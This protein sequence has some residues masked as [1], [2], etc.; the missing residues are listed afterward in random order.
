MTKS[1]RLV[2]AQRI[3]EKRM[4]GRQIK[5]GDLKTVIMYVLPASGLSDAPSRYTT[6]P[7][8]EAKL[9]QLEKTWW[10]YIPESDIVIEADEV[11]EGMDYQ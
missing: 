1:K 10:K 6:R 3:N 9:A 8:I 11:T 2:D 7:A 5:E 4:K